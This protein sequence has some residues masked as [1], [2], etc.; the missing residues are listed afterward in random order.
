MGM[1]GLL[2]VRL[3][4][5]ARERLESGTESLVKHIHATDRAHGHCKHKREGAYTEAVRERRGGGA[6]EEEESNRDRQT[7]RTQLHRPAH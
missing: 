5:A 3:W 2:G 6:E 4:L 1:R 7:H